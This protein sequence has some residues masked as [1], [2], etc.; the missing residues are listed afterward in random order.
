[1]ASRRWFLQAGAA[2]GARVLLPWEWSTSREAATRGRGHWSVPRA[3][4]ETVVVLTKF[5]EQLPAAI[6]TIDAKNGG[7]FDLA[8]APSMH[9]FHAGLPPTPTW[10]YAGASYL[11]PTFEAKRGVPITVRWTNNLGA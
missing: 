6:P 7:T 9:R 10:G 1:M 3:Y 5:A 2:A 8:M 11:G 4:A